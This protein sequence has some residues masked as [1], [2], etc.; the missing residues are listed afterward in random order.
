MKNLVWLLLLVPLLGA[1]AACGTQGGP[2]PAGPAPADLS[3]TYVVTSV[4]ERGAERP[5]I[6]GSEVRISFNDGTLG[7]H[8][9]CNHLSGSYSVAGDELEVG[10]IGGTEMG[11]PQPLMDQ[12]TWLAGLFTGTVTVGE[13]P[14]TLTSGDVVLTLAPRAE[15]SPDRPLVGT[16][17]VLDGVVDGQSVGSVP[18]GPEV[19]LTITD[20]KAATVSGLCNGFGAE[21][22]IAGETISWEP[23]MRTLLAGA[24]PA[25]QDL[26]EQVSSLLTGD[27]TY[28]IEERQLTIRRD[29]IG[30]TFRAD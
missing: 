10:P 6:D 3:G 8:A 30:L 14:L 27:T 12:D 20:G 2:T 28:V 17:W 25:R 18:A 23:G 11:C 19:V 9:G 1:V 7:I 21:V 15:V 13:D 26:D 5:L 4:T 24:D 22:A 16:R 29:A